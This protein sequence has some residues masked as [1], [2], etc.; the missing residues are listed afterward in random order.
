MPY[1]NKKQQK[2]AQQLH[3]KQNAVAYRVRD[4]N[5]LEAARIFVWEYKK[6]PDV[7]CV[8]CGESRWQCLDFH[9][10]DPSQKIKNISG[11]VISRYS[12]ETIQKEIDKCEVLCKNCHAIHHNGYKWEENSNQS[13][14]GAIGPQAG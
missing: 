8:D 13:G 6:R 5:R 1:K 11:M 4:K 9:H 3:Y 7:F 2:E 14:Q 12:V 10:T